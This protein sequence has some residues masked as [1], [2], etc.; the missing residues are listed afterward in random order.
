MATTETAHRRILTDLQNP[1][2]Q[3][4]VAAPKEGNYLVLAG[5]GSGKTK[6]I[7]HRIAW[8]LKEAMVLPEEIMVLTYNRSAAIQIRQRLWALVGPDAGGVSIQ[9]LHSLA[10][11]LTGTSF[12]VAIERGETLQFDAVIRLATEQLRLAD[13]GDELDGML[14]RERLLSG[15]RYLLVDESQV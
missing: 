4:I 6:V 5:P 1:E 2:Q 7:V 12:A 3:A 9:T 13:L 8:L 14:Q 10:M 15:L 11:R